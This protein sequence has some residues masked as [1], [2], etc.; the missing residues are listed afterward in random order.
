[1]RRSF[2]VFAGPGP[3]ARLA[4][5]AASLLLRG[6]AA[7]RPF[8]S[9]A[10]MS[11][12]AGTDDHRVF[13]DADGTIVFE[14]RGGAPPAGA[15]VFSHGLGDSGDGWLD[16]AVSVFSP[17]LPRARIYLPSAPEQ[18]VTV[19]DGAEMPSWFDIAS[20]D[21]SRANQP[22]TGIDASVAR[23]GRLL[24]AAERAG[25][26]RGAAVLAGFSQGGA[27]ALH[28]GLSHALPL[29]GILAAS[30]YLPLADELEPRLPAQRDLPVLM[31]HGSA[32]GVVAPAL[33]RRARDWLAG[34]G[35][36]VDWREYPMA[37]EV[38]AAE[39]RDVS[40][41]LAARLG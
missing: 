5:A 31:C 22:C 27:V 37:H 15:L 26:P 11:S 40:R 4:L 2:R 36:A 38:C 41:W 19:N 34:H 23:V 32:D 20:L 33:G 25:A 17:A 35:Y 10:A 21:R 28:A 13:R 8:S 9:R 14:P 6:A 3:T 7:A 16:A 1:M 39:I 30:T 24:D 18:P 29:A 12:D